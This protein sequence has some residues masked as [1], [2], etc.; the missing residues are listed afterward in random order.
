[1][2]IHILIVDDEPAMERLVIQAL[3]LGDN[4]DYEFSYANSGDAGLAAIL[5]HP[6]TDVVLS[7]INMPGSI[8]GL[9]LLK[10]IHER[11]IPIATIIVS[12]YGDMERARTAIQNGAFDFI[13]KPIE[14]TDLQFSVRR[15]ASYIL[16]VKRSQEL[17]KRV[18]EQQEQL[19]ESVTRLRKT[20]GGFIDAM[21]LTLETRDPYTAGH[22]KRVSDLSRTIATELNLPPDMIEGVRIAGIIHDLGKIY[23]PSE[24][25]NK[26]GRLLEIEFNLIKTHP[27][28]AYNIL[29][30]IEFPWPIA[31]IIY[32]HHERLDGSGYPRGL[33]G[34]EIKLEASIISVA[35]V[36]EAMASHR[37]YRPALGMEVALAEIEKN[38]GVHYPAEVV[39][40]CLNLCR[41]KG[42]TFR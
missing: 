17:L 3:R 41:N 31:E 34:D 25:L 37:P 2:P 5:E 36:V 42:Y 35:D 16:E 40:V 26:P 21:N 33:K 7:D 10:E 20:M 29:K 4:P 15:A 13:Q 39:D 9:G 1:M 14:R 27:E 23:V 18:D 19:K 8:D 22:Q 32:Q 12:A 6:E 11:K 28:I 38:R 24:I 30:S